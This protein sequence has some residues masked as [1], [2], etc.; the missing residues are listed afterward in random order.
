LVQN[1]GPFDWRLGP[2]KVGRKNAKT[3]PLMIV[4]YAETFHGGV[5]SA[6]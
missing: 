2:G 5:H 3:P 6:A 4:A 1:V